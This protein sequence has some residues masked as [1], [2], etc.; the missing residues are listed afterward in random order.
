[1]IQKCIITTGERRIRSR[2]VILQTKGWFNG[3]G[4]EPLCQEG[5]NTVMKL[6]CIDAG[7]SNIK[8]QVFDETGPISDIISVPPNHAFDMK[9]GIIFVEKY[10]RTLRKCLKELIQNLKVKGIDAIGLMTMGPSCVIF[11]GKKYR[12]IVRNYNFQDAQKGVKKIL[13]MNLYHIRGKGPGS[14]NTPEQ[15]IQLRKDKKLPQ[16]PLFTTLASL[17]CHSLGA[18]ID[19]W[20]YPEAS[21][22]GLTDV[23][24]GTYSEKMFKALK[25]KTE[26]FPKFTT[27]SVGYLSEEICKDLKTENKKKIP[28]FNFGTDGPATQAYFGKEFSTFKI[29]STGA[30]RVKGKHPIFERKPLLKGYPGVWNIFFKEPKGEQY[31]VSGATINAGGNTVTYYF[32]NGPNHKVDWKGMDLKLI[33]LMNQKIPS[34]DEIGVELPFEFGERDGIKRRAGIV[35]KKPKDKILLYYAIKEGVMFNMM[36]RV[37]L[38]RD[39]QREAGNK[40]SDGFILTGPILKSKPWIDLGLVMLNLIARI[41]EPKFIKP[42][43]KEIGLATVAK[44]IFEKMGIEN[45]ISNRGKIFD[46]D[47]LSFDLNTKKQEMLLTRWRKYLECY[48]GCE[49]NF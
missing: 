43:Y 3:S 46:L 23:K 18:H 17:L 37:L 22:N 8:A 4:L 42:K 1:M 5:N 16:K 30:F 10:I 36:Q 27:D 7:T 14:Q 13:K 34:L 24:T 40:L 49:E 33:R 45:E 41:K 28:I 31:F 25:F 12:K 19:K 6:I 29:E 35:G 38:V 20:T 32:K 9:K 11:D 26:W 48:E 44:G 15:I 21:Y 47:T 2:K 39:A